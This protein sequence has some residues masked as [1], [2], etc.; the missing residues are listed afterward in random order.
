MGRTYLRDGYGARPR[1]G[2]A[3]RSAVWTGL[4][5]ALMVGISCTGRGAEVP[6]QPRGEP[7]SAPGPTSTPDTSPPERLQARPVVWV[8]VEGA[9]VLPKVDV[10]ARRVLR[11]IAVS[12]RPHNITVARGTVVASLPDA[13]LVAVVHRGR[14]RE[15]AVGGAPHDPKPAGRWIVVTNEGAARLELLSRSGRWRGSIPLRADPHDVAVAP[16][17][18]VAWASL[19]GDDALAVVDLPNREVRRYVRTGV[20]PHDLLF[21]PDGR[22]WVTD[23]SGVLHVLTRGGE[24]FRTLS[25]GEETHHLTFEPGGVRGWV[26]DNDTRRLLAIDIRRLRAEVEVSTGGAPHHVAVTAD[27]RWIVVADNTNGRLILYRAADGG[28]AGS[29]AVGPGPHGVWAVP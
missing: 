25:V 17:G 2:P 27:G 14:L 21:A 22:L 4:L 15:V 7:E 23:W 1:P 5:A 16:G 8:A 29:I 20:Q 24:I 3:E 12:G 18:R 28:R 6:V 11:R 13:G 19:D 10:G 26:T 9:G